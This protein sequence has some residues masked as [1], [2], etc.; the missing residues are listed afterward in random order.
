MPDRDHVSEYGQLTLLPP[1][2]GFPTADCD[3]WLTTTNASPPLHWPNAE[4]EVGHTFISFFRSPCNKSKPNTVFSASSVLPSPPPPHPALLRMLAQ[5]RDLRSVL[6][7]AAKV[8]LF[9][10]CQYHVLCMRDKLVSVGEEQPYT[11]KRFVVFCIRREA[12]T[13]LSTFHEVGAGL[14]ETRCI[15]WAGSTMVYRA[16]LICDCSA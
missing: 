1:T 4:L 6:P 15:Q 5:A 10:I 3:T 14:K 13:S 2:G 7:V 12:S 9:R 11:T 8:Q 16:V